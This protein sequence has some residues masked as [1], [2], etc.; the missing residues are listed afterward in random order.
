M[1]LNFTYISNGIVITLTNLQRKE[2]RKEGRH[3]WYNTNGKKV[4]NDEV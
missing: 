3:Y 1:E 2:G 4:Y